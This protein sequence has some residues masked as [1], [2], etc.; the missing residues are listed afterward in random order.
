MTHRFPGDDHNMDLIQ[1]EEKHYE[2]QNDRSQVVMETEFANERGTINVNM[3]DLHM[4]QRGTVRIN[5]DSSV[6]RTDEK[7]GKRKIT[8]D[9]DEYP[10][11]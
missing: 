2:R 10:L 7:Q 11:G 5:F 6:V 4:L 1:S 3:N 9:D 8:F